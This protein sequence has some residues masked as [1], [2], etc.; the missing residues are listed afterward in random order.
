MKLLAFMCVYYVKIRNWEYSE[1]VNLRLIVKVKKKNV[2]NFNR[3]WNIN[4]IPLT[5]SNPVCTRF[6]YV[7]RYIEVYDM[8]FSFFLHSSR[9][10][11]MFVFFFFKIIN[12]VGMNEVNLCLHY[13]LCQDDS[14]SFFSFLD[15]AF[16]WSSK[17]ALKHF[18]LIRCIRIM[19]I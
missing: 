12:F 3:K 13:Q 9:L 5:N 7:N 1:I 11:F 14:F 18:L 19:H 2:R 8:F 10:F 16:E 17:P 4:K 6:D 15:I